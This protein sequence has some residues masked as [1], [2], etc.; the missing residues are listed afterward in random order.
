MA[1]GKSFPDL[2]KEFIFQPAAMNRAAMMPD[3]DILAGMSQGYD[4]SQ[5]D[6]MLRTTPLHP[7]LILGA[8][9]VV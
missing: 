6:G 4:D 2:L 8:G 3:Q 5:V 7:S 1:S 9:G